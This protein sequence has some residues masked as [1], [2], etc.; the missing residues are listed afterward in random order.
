MQKNML[1]TSDL[2]SQLGLTLFR[3][4][5]MCHQNSMQ[6]TANSDCNLYA[7]YDNLQEKSEDDLLCD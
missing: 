5:A 1:R 4:P 2:F 7:A 3:N 6:I